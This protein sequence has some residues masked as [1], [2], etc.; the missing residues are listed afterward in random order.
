[1]LRRRRTEGTY[2]DFLHRLITAAFWRHTLDPEVRRRRMWVLLPLALLV[3]L[4][5]IGVLLADLL[6]YL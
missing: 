4:F 6:G 2:V 1:M 3:A 5:A